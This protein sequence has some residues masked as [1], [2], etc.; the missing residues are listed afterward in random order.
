MS[1]AHLDPNDPAVF[2]ALK[3]V[4]NP[5]SNTNWFVSNHCLF[6]TLL[7]LLLHALI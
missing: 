7:V 1:Y 3:D 4:M 6:V 2:D 5:R